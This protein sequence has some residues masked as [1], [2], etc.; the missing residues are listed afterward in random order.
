MSTYQRQ[1]REKISKFEA[2][3]T[4]TSITRIQNGKILIY[5]CLQWMIFISRNC[6][7]SIK[8][9]NFEWIKQYNMYY[10]HEQILQIQK[11]IPDS[12]LAKRDRSIVMIWLLLA[13][14]MVV[15]TNVTNYRIVPVQLI[16]PHKKSKRSNTKC[17]EILIQEIYEK[18]GKMRK[19]YAN[20][21]GKVMKWYHTHS[22]WS[23]NVG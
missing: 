21:V 9:P 23:F 1:M 14:L 2:T 22:K 12:V 8:S 6:V 17:G 16:Y 4:G 11:E 13:H 10:G 5:V 20:I 7:W 19:K 3:L 18:P 15:G